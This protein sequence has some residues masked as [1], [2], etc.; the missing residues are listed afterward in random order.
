MSKFNSK[1]VVEEVVDEIE[2]LLK[3]KKTGRDTKKAEKKPTVTAPD[4]AEL[5]LAKYLEYDKEYETEEIVPCCFYFFWGS[6]L[7]CCTEVLYIFYYA[8]HVSVN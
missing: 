7:A 1:V 2:A 6:Y 3:P 8:S 5:A 4:T